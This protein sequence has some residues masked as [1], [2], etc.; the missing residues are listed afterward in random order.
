M[1]P[2]TPIAWLG[3]LLALATPF[4]SLSAQTGR[5]STPTAAEL[6]K[7]DR[8][9]NGTLDADELA[10]KEADEARL[11]K[12]VDSTGRSALTEPIVNMSPFEV[13]EDKRGYYGMTTMSGTR[14]NSKIE[15]LASSITIV[16]KEQ[17]MDF[18]MLNVHDVFNYEASTEGMGNYSDIAN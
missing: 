15:D 10:A 8:N 18:A 11:A 9:R 12:A 14:L 7:Y 16:T 1:S 5:T 3:S 13:M 2:R 17:M 6:A 4:D